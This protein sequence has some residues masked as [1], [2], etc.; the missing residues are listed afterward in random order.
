MQLMP[1]KEMAEN[2]MDCSGLDSV[3]FGDEIR[4]KE[5]R[6]RPASGF[7]N[8]GSY[9][10]VPRRVLDVQ[11]RY[12]DIMESH[13]D[14][15]FRRTAFEDWNDAR[16]SVA[17][18]VSAD[19]EDIVF[20]VNATSGVNTVVRSLKLEPGDAILGTSLTYGSLKNLWH[21]MAENISP[22]VK[23]KFLEIKIPIISEDD[24]IQQFD[25]YLSKNLEVKFV[26]ID[27]ITSPSAILMP[28]KRLGAVCHKHGA[29][30][31]V[32]GAHA[33][34][35]VHLNLKDLNVDFYTGNMHKWAYTPRGCALLWVKREHHGMVR[36]PLTSWEKGRSIS[37]QFFNQGT[38]DFIPFFCAK[39]ALQFY[40]AIGGMDKAVGYTRD[41]A[42]RG[43][44]LLC[45]E[46]S[47]ERLDI[48]S[49]METPN[50]RMIRLPGVPKSILG[51]ERRDAALK[52]Q[53]DVYNKHDIQSVFDW[54]DGALYLRISTQVHNTLEDI[55]KLVPVLKGL[56]DDCVSY[57]KWSDAKNDV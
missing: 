28:V 15:W 50:L 9:G 21:D 46:L 34:G 44:D 40:Q 49:S 5:F 4:Q 1:D 33:P 17:E 11:K 30:V 41:L 20:V 19:V 10:S 25:D 27:H 38:R 12:L 55:R 2:K 36:P 22:G 35:Q 47:L 7:M 26:L 6:L 16:K 14:H 51:F 42:T 54:V 13:P 43:R 32:D 31:M 23:A 8:N 24:L 37:E 18:F 56:M 53:E 48:P 57:D 3:A 45:K 39:H 52:L 29:M